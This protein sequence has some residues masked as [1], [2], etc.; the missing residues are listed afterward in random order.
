M[1]KT[2]VHLPDGVEEVIEELV[3]QSGGTLEIPTLKQADVVRLL[4]RDACHRLIDG[5]LMVAEETAEVT[6]IDAETLEELVPKTARAKFL[7]NDEKDENWLADMK[8]GFEGRVRD[9]LEARFKSGYEPEAVREVAQGYIREA[10]IFWLMVE[11]DR[12]T[13]EE[14]KRYVVDKVEEYKRKYNVSEYDPDEEFLA[15]FSGVQEGEAQAEVDGAREQI[16]A[17]ATKRIRDGSGVGR[18][19]LAHSLAVAFDVDE[20]AVEEIV[21]EVKRENMIAE[22]RRA[23]GAV[24]ETPALMDG[25]VGVAHDGHA[26]APDAD[27][28]AEEIDGVLVD[29]DE[30]AWMLEGDVEEQIDKGDGPRTDGGRRVA[31]PGTERYWSDLEHAEADGGDEEDPAPTV[32]ERI[33][34][35]LDAEQIHGITVTAK[36]GTTTYC[37]VSQTKEQHGGEVVDLRTVVVDLAE[38]TVKVS[39]NGLWIPRDSETLEGLTQVVAR[40]T[41][42]VG[43]GREYDE[44]VRASIDEVDVD[45]LLATEIA[46]DDYDPGVDGWGD[47]WGNGQGAPPEIHEFVDRLLEADVETERFSRLDYGA[48]SP[49]ERYA[50]RPASELMGN[51]G[52]ETLEDDPLIVIDVDDPEDAPL[53]ELPETYAVSSPHGDD[54]RAHHFYRVEGKEAVYDHFGSWAVKPGWGDVWIAGEYVVGPGSMLNGCQK[55]DC[56]EC[57]KPEG[58]RYTVHRDTAIESLDADD[59]IDLLESSWS[60]DEDDEDADDLDGADEPEQDAVET[61]AVDE[62]DGEDDEHTVECHDCGA[63]IPDEDA[64]LADRDGAP[65]YVCGGGCE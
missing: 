41:T 12:E 40:T 17:I 2:S 25:G 23:E 36:R 5:D 32:R 30:A 51:Y 11:D 56:H 38:E 52:V 34:E 8:G 35:E 33:E 4:L 63:E 64:V 6:G 1:K 7:Y 53:D 20:S 10:R 19:E 27:R 3:R 18:E 59:L 29:E 65:V 58:G 42:E 60:R 45:D 49:W 14:K 39:D 21:A 50:N 13:F 26:R 48:K 28:E 47:S 9:R 16:R 37:V 54:R 62:D 31:S 22:Q 15:G 46:P 55:D 43:S 57:A 44:P 61:D 24:E